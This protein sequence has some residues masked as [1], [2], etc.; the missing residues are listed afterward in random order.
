MFS[1]MTYPSRV[2]MHCSPHFH[3]LIM[4][5][6]LM[7]LELCT[8]VDGLPFPCVCILVY[9]GYDWAFLGVDNSA[10]SDNRYFIDSVI[11]N[12]L[13]VDHFSCLGYDLDIITC[14]TAVGSTLDKGTL[15]ACGM[16]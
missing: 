13:Y 4:Y 10:C 16:T 8:G 1:G 12:A 14:N 11:V 9:D 15:V 7:C 3:G 5:N 2:S 6:L